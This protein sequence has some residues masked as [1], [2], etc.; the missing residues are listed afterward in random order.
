MLFTSLYYL[1][2][3]TIWLLIV[4]LLL[5]KSLN[6]KYKDSIPARFFLKNNPPFEKEL[7]H[8]HSC[9]LGEVRA[10]K[11]I[12]DKLKQEVNIST[13]TNT[14]FDEAKKL[15]KNVRFLPYEIFLPFWYK[16][17]KLL[18][19]LEAELWYMLFFIAKKKG[20]KTILLNAR[21][22]DKSYKNYK[23]LFFFY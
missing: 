16:K 7:V 21:I 4:P 23:R 15:S 8:F 19:V 2:A 22:S 14:G 20:V 11:P 10:I 1:F 6:K 13:T 3:T 18:V 12:I 17:Q 5:Y 9:S